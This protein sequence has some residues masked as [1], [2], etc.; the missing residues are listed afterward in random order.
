M[1]HKRLTLL[2]IS[3]LLGAFSSKASAAEQTAQTPVGITITQSEIVPT[4]NQIVPMN[5]DQCRSRDRPATLP[6]TN[7]ERLPFLSVLGSL[8]LATAAIIIKKKEGSKY[9]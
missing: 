3:L 4:P 2:Y 1:K 7:E 8:M 5:Q 6:R 9:E